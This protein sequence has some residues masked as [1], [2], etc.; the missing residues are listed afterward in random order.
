MDEERRAV[1]EQLSNERHQ[2]ATAREEMLAE[3]RRIIAECYEE[4]RKLADERN[5]LSSMQRDIYD[6]NGTRHHSHHESG[7]S[8]IRLSFYEFKILFIFHAVSIS[9][10][11]KYLFHIL[12]IFIHVRA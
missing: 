1:Q 6:R 3:Q 11:F 2:M 8:K 7:V 12:H 4:K 5:Q 10:K 9:F